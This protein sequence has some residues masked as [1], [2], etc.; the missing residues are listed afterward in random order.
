MAGPSADR[1]G[2]DAVM[3]HVA[4]M[5]QD[6]G[7][8]PVV[9][10]PSDGPA[11]DAL[12]EAGI[13]TAIAATAVLRRSD[14]N[15]RGIWRLVAGLP[16]ALLACVRS[17][18]KERPDVLWVNTVTIPLWVVIGRL[19]RLRV[20][21]HSHELVAG[22]RL[23]RFVMYA[24]SLFAHRVILVSEACRRDIAAVYPRLA[25]RCVV[26]VNP[27]FGVAAPIPVEAGADGDVVVLGRLS[28]RKGQ[29]LLLAALA[30]IDAARPPTVHLCGD[31]FPSPAGELYETAL[32]EA[33]A[34]LTTAVEF[35]GYVERL[36]AYRLG[37][38]VVV[39]SLE[40]D[41][42]PL[43][44]SEAL[45]AGRAIVAADCGGIPEQLAG[46]GALFPA[47]DVAG[48]AAA[49]KQTIDD[50]DYRE[51]LARRSLERSEQLSVASY[52][53]RLRTVIAG[54]TPVPGRGR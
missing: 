8:K 17:L 26:L 16:N 25:A 9:V 33:A 37:G 30:E 3:G 14:L 10:L 38:I 19:L 6:D 11:M 39:P 45:A 5:L 20:V 27:A 2:A 41:P 22:S 4:A 1:Y 49:L 34:T 44:V 42:C 50:V 24:P 32:R 51:D 15:L 12:A 54:V 46:A 13:P 31:I 48:L 28:Q 29:H 43:V 21:L 40:P 36:T 18:R 52:F 23:R 47:G 7:N 53:E 35:H